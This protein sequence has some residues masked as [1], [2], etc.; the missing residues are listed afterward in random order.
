MNIQLKKA[1]IVFGVSGILYFLLSRKTNSR[2]P[3]STK[4]ADRGQQQKN[5]IIVANAY[6]MAKKDRATQEQLEELNKEA[7]K[8]YGLRVDKKQSDGFYYVRDILGNEILK[9]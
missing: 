8:K 6:G 5:A 2:K 4:E 1:L 7:E 9:I 3:A